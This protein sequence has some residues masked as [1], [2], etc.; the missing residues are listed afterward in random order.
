MR[1]CGGKRRGWRFLCAVV[2]LVGCANHTEE[3]AKACAGYVCTAGS[4]Q[5]GANGPECVCGAFEQALGLTCTRLVIDPG[6]DDDREHARL[7]ALSTDVAGQIEV[8]K[9][10]R[11][12]DVDVYRFEADPGRVYLVEVV[13]GPELEVRLEDSNGAQQTYNYGTAVRLATPSMGGAEYITLRSMDP[14]VIGQYLFRVTDLAPAVQPETLGPAPAFAEGTIAPA[15][16]VDIFPLAVEFGVIYDVTCTFGDGFT[17]VF[18][19]GGRSNPAHFKVQEDPG[20]YSLSVSGGE[21]GVGTYRCDLKRSDVQDDVGDSL[22][23]ALQL[24]GPP[25]TFDGRAEVQPDNDVFAIQA[26]AGKYLWAYVDAC[27]AT[28]RRAPGQVIREDIYGSYAHPG[29][30]GDEI[31]YLNIHCDGASSYRLTVEELVDVEGDSPATAIPITIGSFHGR[32]EGPEDRDLFE[33]QAGAA[34]HVYTL[35]RALVGTASAFWEVHGEG[36]NAGYAVVDGAVALAFSSDHP[37]SVFVTASPY[38]GFSVAR[39]IDYAP[40]LED[41]G[42]ID[43]EPG[44]PDLALPGVIGT[45][46]HGASQFGLDRDCFAFDLPPSQTFFVDAPSLFA[47]VYLPDGGVLGS[48]SSGG[49]D[50][51][52]GGRH[53]VC[54]NPGGQPFRVMDYPYTLN[55]HP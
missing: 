22:D 52:P 36:V 51:G 42:V 3:D 30:L 26:H 54:V 44:T 12:Q 37:G 8:P 55:V 15:G 41:T 39:P 7:I 33:F 2:S 32:L 27:F 10:G 19:A 38:D 16:E 28:F 49:F 1:P 5:A 45:D 17:G 34:R 6:D 43:P 29:L 53:V 21:H 13:S 4:C 40:L 47:E 11:S 48:G 24:P 14:H 31:A 35:S 18:S 23:T 9:L 46:V 20:H 25:A 50:S